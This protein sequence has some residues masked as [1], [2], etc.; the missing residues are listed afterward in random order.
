MED[1]CNTC[2]NCFDVDVADYADRAIQKV[3][4]CT[5]LPTLFKS[6]KETISNRK[7]KI[8]RCEH[9]FKRSV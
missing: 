5:I 1:K 9:Y 8:T 2:E 6:I 7:L 4:V 3:R